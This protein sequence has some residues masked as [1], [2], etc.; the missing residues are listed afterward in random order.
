MEI[1]NLDPSKIQK[2]GLPQ[3]LKIRGLP[4]NMQF[5]TD[6][7]ISEQLSDKKAEAILQK[8]VKESQSGRKV[9][10]KTFEKSV[11]LTSHPALSSKNNQPTNIVQKTASKI[12]DSMSC[13]LYKQTFQKAAIE[14]AM[15][16][17]SRCNVPEN[18]KDWCARDLLGLFENK[19][20]LNISE[21]LD[22]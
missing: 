12:T 6:K 9:E 14:I 16:G 3:T 13:D 2:I 8:F 15:S 1:H 5:L 4:E 7:L 21:N 19:I 10:K 22:K 11:S 18:L 20:R 17:W